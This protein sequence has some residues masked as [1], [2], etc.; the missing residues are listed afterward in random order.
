MNHNRVINF[1]AGPSALP[2]A[3]LE[4]ARDELV[5][6]RGTGMSIMEHSHR[7]KDY[8]ACHNEAIALLRE[9]LG[10]PER[11]KVLFLQGG[12][13]QAFATV[14]MNLL[15]PGRSADYVVTGGWGE[16]AYDEARTVGEARLAG[17]DLGKRYTRIPAQAEHSFDP[18]ACYVHITSNNTLEGTQYKDF[19]ETGE[20]PLV[21]DMSS[22]FL[23]RRFDVTR[24]GLIYA[25]A[26]KNLGPSGVTLFLVRDDLLAA[27]RKDIP[28]YFRYRVHAEN[29]SLYNTPPTF[30]IYMVRNVLAWLKST[31]GLDAIEQ[32]NREK[33]E[34]VYGAID[35]QRDFYRCPVE[36]SARSLMNVVFRLPD[37]SLEERFVAEARKAGMVGL[38][39]HRSTGGIR[40]SMYNATSPADVRVLADFMAD[41]VKRQG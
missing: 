20:V 3:V 31:G 9:L 28:K 10:V 41:F 5:N 29:N 37:E 8:E 22:D 4:Q 40:V 19:P 27:G 33:G 13:S 30:G 26:Q 35:A 11:W 16:K 36:P 18:G 15:Q 14:P 17:P 23:S 24:F 25:G 6:Y 34:V 38:K 7:G 32:R 39:G 21:A 2:L 12:A 1:N